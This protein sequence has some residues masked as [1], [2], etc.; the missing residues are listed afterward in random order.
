MKL[1]FIGAG[2]LATNLAPALQTAGCE[3]VEVWSKTRASAEALAARM[4]CRASWGRVGD[5]TRDADLYILSI[6]DTA[7]TDVIGELH[8]GR[9]RAL[10]AHT[11][12][13]LPLSLFAEAGHERGAVFYPM[14]TF[15]KERAVDFRQ[16]H[17]FIEAS[18][19]ADHDMLHALAALLTADDH[20][21]PCTSAMRRRLHLAAVFACNFVNHCCTLADDILQDGGLDFGVMLPLLDETVAKLHLLPPRQAQTGPAARRDQ[22]VMG[23]QR[24]MLAD[25]PDLQQIYTLLSNS[26]MNNNSHLT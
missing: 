20:I 4:G 16:V 13:S 17:F 21:H 26:I 15:S 23:M 24:A 10:F 1:A 22:N 18:L 14:Q 5:A 2:R 9:E 8:D 12:G 25:R 7:L 19:P 11:A 3:V 6:K